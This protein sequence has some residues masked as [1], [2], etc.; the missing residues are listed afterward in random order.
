M[1]K[2]IIAA[3]VA[4]F[5][6]SQPLLSQDIPDKRLSFEVAVVV[7]NNSGSP[8]SKILPIPLNGGE[9]RI[10]NISLRDLLTRAFGIES[11]AL[12]GPRWLDDRRFDIRAKVPSARSVSQSDVNQ[13]LMALLVERF[14]LKVH[15]EQRRVSGYELR[16]T[17]EVKLKRSDPLIP[18]GRS[19]G[20]T[21]IAGEMSLSE[22]T[23][24][25]ADVLGK[26][27]R[28]LTE[29]S[30]RFE[31]RLTWRPD[32]LDPL[33]ATSQDEGNGKSMASLFTAI[34]EQLGLQLKAA[35]VF[36]EIVV[37]DSISDTPN[38]P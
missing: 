36:T 37:I 1:S 31:V 15:R 22:L 20:A 6:G 9:F 26:P 23:N 25:L 27:V 38:E 24:A 29:I 28:D 30:G 12:T 10:V 17:R 33:I 34:V 16:V 14:R 2:Q 7:P 11:Y 35:S 3:L 19:R 32:N 13:M 21:L 8:E 5:L 4:L 18:R